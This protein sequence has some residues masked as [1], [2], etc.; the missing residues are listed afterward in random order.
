[1]SDDIN[2][3]SSPADSGGILANEEIVADIG[4][5]RIELTQRARVLMVPKLVETAAQRIAMEMLRGFGSVRSQPI[6][7]WEDSVYGYI[8]KRFRL[9]KG[10][11]YHYRLQYVTMC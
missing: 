3:N 5:L 9:E 7:W 4:T 2:T 10:N 8:I 1:M 6:T 11:S